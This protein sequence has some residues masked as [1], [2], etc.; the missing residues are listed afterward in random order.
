[1]NALTWRLGRSWQKWRALE[2][3]DHRLLIE[4]GFF[5]ALARA[6]IRFLPFRRAVLIFG[7]EEC[8]SARADDT[9]APVEAAR[10]AWAV[11][12]VATRIP[13]GGTCLAQALAGSAM[14]GRRGITSTIHLGVAKV[15]DSER[16]C[17]HAWLRCGDGMLTG[18][19]GSRSFTQVAVFMVHPTNAAPP[20]ETVLRR[21]PQR[22]RQAAA[23]HG[24][25]LQRELANV[26]QALAAGGISDVIVL[27][28]LPLALRIFGS[29]AEREMAD[30]DLLVHPRNVP[31]ALSV[32]DSLGYKKRFDLEADFKRH[33]EITLRRMTSA[34]YLDV[35]FHWKA[36]ASMN[37]IDDRFVWPRTER[38]AHQGVECL[39]LD[40]IMT[41]VHLAYHYVHHEFSVPRILRDFAQAWN[42][43]HD[44]VDVGELLTVARETEHLAMLE[45]TFV[46]AAQGGLLD[47]P[48][49]SIRTLR[50][51]VA[52]HVLDGRFGKTRLERKVIALSLQRPGRTF[53]SILRGLV[54][55][56]S[57][58]RFMYGDEESHHLA[59]FYAVRPVEIAARAVRSKAYS[60]AS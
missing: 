21:L 3:A 12:A 8:R 11:N 30:I 39:V 2:P 37:E 28:G 20:V 10:S 58:M 23:R 5:L 53:H 15:P 6:S 9:P 25:V 31:A 1:M 34:G 48:A 47:V 27:K 51:E 38:F 40:P 56:P 55:P 4:A 13:S 7:L 22:R 17:A 24:L 43:W 26:L 59:R 32:L 60:P 42:V 35:D 29:V 45:V 52:L 16:L 49:P 41:I 19:A 14:L 18:S 46:R 50:A 54:P 36:F 44:Q 57:E 33:R